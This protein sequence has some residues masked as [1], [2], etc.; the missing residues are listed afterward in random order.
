MRHLRRKY[1]ANS[2]VWRGFTP[3]FGAVLLPSLARFYSRVWRSVHE[4]PQRRLCG[5]QAPRQASGTNPCS[6][7]LR[8]PGKTDANERG[9]QA[10][11]IDCSKPEVIRLI[12]QFDLKRLRRSRAFSVAFSSR[13]FPRSIATS[14][15]ASS[16]AFRA[17]ASRLRINSAISAASARTDS[18]KFFAFWI[19]L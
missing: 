12:C 10:H 17:S 14:V 6:R 16:Q 15:A 13:S 7:R 3:E 19:S 9:F 8:S 4:P 18:K 5:T 11:R 1:T 2:R